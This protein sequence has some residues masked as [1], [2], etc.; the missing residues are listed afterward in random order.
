MRRARRE[1]FESLVSV[2]GQLDAQGTGARLLFLDA[3]ES[4]LIS[5]FKETRRRHPLADTGQVGGGIARERELLAPIKG[6]ADVSIDTSDLS[7]AR[8]RKIVADKMLLR[9]TRGQAGRHLPHL[10]LQARRAPRR[11]PPL[12]RALPPQPAL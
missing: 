4:A 1:Y 8:L 7:A 9:S 3:S 5:R 2:L 12:R 11:R 6:R 10:R